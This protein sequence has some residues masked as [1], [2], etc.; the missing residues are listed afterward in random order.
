MRA[1]ILLTCFALS[2]SLIHA[3]KRKSTYRDGL[4]AEVTTGKGLIVLQLEFEKT[5]MT[6]SSF[7][8]LSE[9]TIDN[10]TFPKGTPYFN[11]TKYHRVVPGHVIQCGAPAGGT[12]QGP[13]YQFPNEIRLPE[14]SHGKAGM[15]QMANG[16]PHT[17][18][19]QWCITLGD[20]SYLDGDYTVF[21]HVVT[22]MEVV[23]S[24]VQGD[25]IQ[26]IKIV[27]IGTAA[28]A[29]HPTTESFRAMVE[30]AKVEV[31]KAEAKRMA[32]EQ[33]MIQTNWP[34]A[35]DFLKFV[36]LKTG[37][38]P[39][40][41]MGSTLKMKYTGKFIRGGSFIS[42]ADGGKPWFGSMPEEFEFEIGKS[43]INAGFDACVATM[44]KGEQRVLIIPAEQAY[45][46][47]GYYPPERKGEKRF[48]VSPNETIVYEVEV[49]EVS[50]R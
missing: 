3:Q 25:E 32:E 49:V 4:Y 7:V 42:T 19:S 12:Q 23:N 20:R 14:L 44:R 34:G 2:A 18:G 46:I 31:E 47:G 28:N 33:Q 37:D 48:H 45:G 6:V 5:P 29:F 9:G 1:T 11:G 13:G 10:A 8:G 35:K 43:T 38:G 22:G 50:N 30:A 40:P 17:N 39:R 16:A 15:V 41:K 21:G 26:K 24:I 27:R 36:V